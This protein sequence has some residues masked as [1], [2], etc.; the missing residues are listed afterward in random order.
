MTQAIPTRVSLIGAAL[1]ICLLLLL[2]FSV[3]PTKASSTKHATASA[4]AGCPPNKKIDNTSVKKVCAGEHPVDCLRRP[5]ARTLDAVLCGYPSSRW[6]EITRGWGC[7]SETADC[8]PR[9]CKRATRL[10]LGFKALQLAV[11]NNWNLT[12]T[13]GFA[14][15]MMFTIGEKVQLS[16]LYRK[17]YMAAENNRALSCGQPSIEANSTQIEKLKQ[18]YGPKVTF[19]FGAKFKFKGTKAQK[20]R[21]LGDVFEKVMKLQEKRKDGFK[22]NK[23]V[24]FPVSLRPG[25][26]TRANGRLAISP[27]GW[28]VRV[29]IR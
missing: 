27:T 22:L 12:I 7:G 17:L 23:S 15:G 29:T 14:T 5:R 11:E 18:G 26:V 2:A 28:N 3:Q 9:T 21:A 13:R 4:V 25:K 8:F 24:K 6:N 16:M 19:S 1:T 10:T 20:A